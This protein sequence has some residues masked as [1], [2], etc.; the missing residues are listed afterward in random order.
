MSD[1]YEASKEDIEVDENEIN[2]YLGQD[3]FGNKYVTVKIEDI[4]EILGIKEDI[5]ND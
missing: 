1:W 4:K 2:I 5:T 3:Y